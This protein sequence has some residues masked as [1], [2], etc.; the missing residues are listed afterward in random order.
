MGRANQDWENWG[1]DQGPRP[2]KPGG[3]QGHV[4]SPLVSIR[5]NK[6]QIGNKQRVGRIREKGSALANDQAPASLTTWLRPHEETEENKIERST[7][8]KYRGTEINTSTRLDKVIG[9]GTQ[10][11]QRRLRHRAQAK[12]QAERPAATRSAQPSRAKNTD[13]NR[14]TS[15]GAYNKNRTRYERW[16]ENK[17]WWGKKADNRVPPRGTVGE[18]RHILSVNANLVSSHTRN[19]SAESKPF[20][21]PRDTATFQK[22]N[23]SEKKQSRRGKRSNE[24]RMRRIEQRKKRRIESRRFYIIFMETIP[25]DEWRPARSTHRDTRASKA[26]GNRREQDMGKNTMEK[27]LVFAK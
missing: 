26:G 1:E 27:G 4:T 21:R 15:R 18:P 6:N 10:R 12:A 16:L 8:M 17:G 5:T 25:K 22:Q 9:T 2:P 7:I 20:D 14:N 11:P 19:K 3:P 23:T 24:A 13:M